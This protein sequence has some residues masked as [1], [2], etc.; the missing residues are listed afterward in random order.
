MDES[1]LGERGKS[2][3]A[4]AWKQRRLILVV[5]DDPDV[6]HYIREVLQE[7]GYRVKTALD[8]LRA[9][10]ALAEELPD[11]VLLDIRMPGMSG[12]EVLG[13]LASVKGRLPIIIMSAADRARDRA[14]LHRNPLY[15]AK[16]LSAPVLL[17][18]VAEAL[19]GEGGAEE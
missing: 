3:E 2:D 19:E 10:G 5:D 16:P 18:T 14:L 6:L 13:Q 4:A 12:D 7:G 17:A 9:M 1:E 11:A 8:G 15:I